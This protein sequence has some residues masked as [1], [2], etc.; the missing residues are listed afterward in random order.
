[1][2]RVIHVTHTARD[3]PK[4]GFGC[5]FGAKTDLKC[6]FGLVSVKVTTPFSHLVLAATIRNWPKLEWMSLWKTY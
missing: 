4:F 5:G 2:I 1:M 6:S 3:R